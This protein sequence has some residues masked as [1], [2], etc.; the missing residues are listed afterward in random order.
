VPAE[1]PAVTRCAARRKPKAPLAKWRVSAVSLAAL[2]VGCADPAGTERTA[3]TRA[4]VVGGE[5][6]PSGGREDAVVMLRTLLDNAELVCSAS[7]VAPNLVVTARHCVSHF[8]TG[9]FRCTVQGELESEDP[10]AGKL[11]IQ[12]EPGSIEVYDG[13]T[14]RTDP[15]AHGKQV[16]STLSETI[17]VN[18]LA[19]VVLDQDVALPILPLRL[20]GRAR[21]GEAV[22]LVGY[23]FDDAMADGDFLDVKTQGRTHNA[24]LVISDVGPVSNADVTSAPPRTIVIKGPAGCIGDS[25]G[26]LLARETGAVL[27]VDSLL[28]GES[29]G[30][31]DARNLFTHVPD[32]T[33]LTDDAFAASGHRPTP[34]PAETEP[35]ADGGRGGAPSDET[36]GAFTADGGEPATN[37]SSG[38]TSTSSGGITSASGGTTNGSAGTTSTSGALSDETGGEP[39]TPAAGNG[40]VPPSHLVPP[41]HGSGC[42]LSPATPRAAAFFPLVLVAVLERIFRVRRR[43]RGRFVRL[44]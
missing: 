38:T 3:A 34:E 42:A 22:T 24:N 23:G 26:P 19:F 16:L 17:C 31:F 5:P 18:D 10:N 27:G 20:N 43:T 40:A 9:E 14:P 2:T 8:V 33:Q 12:V 11:G 36:G 44:R 32:F 6:S 13:H 35:P 28:D 41:H 21:L 37:G 4:A 30:A 25:G 7:V 29:C 39:T 1:F 15:I